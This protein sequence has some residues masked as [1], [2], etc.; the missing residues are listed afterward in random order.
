[1]ASEQD[2]IDLANSNQQV[3]DHLIKE[4]S[5]HDW[6][7]IVA[8]YK[9]VHVVEAVFA[10]HLH[11]HSCSH[12]DREERLKKTRSLMVIFKD[13]SHLLNESRN[14]RYLLCPP[15]RMTFEQVRSQLVYKRLYGVE[16]K[17]IQFLSDAGKARLAKVQP[18][19]KSDASGAL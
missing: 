15:G 1:M 13:Y 11:R 7:A 12:S 10:N 8:F 3:I 18:P 14:F 4:A 9:A 17:A 6:L 2:H 16:Q 19:P 5:F